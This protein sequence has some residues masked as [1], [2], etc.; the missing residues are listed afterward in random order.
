[1]A[2]PQEDDDPVFGDVGSRYLSLMD[3]VVA[4]SSIDGVDF[5]VDS[6]QV[7]NLLKEVIKEHRNVLTR[8]KPHATMKNGRQVV[9]DFNA[10]F[11]GL[12]AMDSIAD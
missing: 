3:K 4:K 1:M 7:Y 6:A 11:Q 5:N 9:L 10:H 12:S 8:I 2:F